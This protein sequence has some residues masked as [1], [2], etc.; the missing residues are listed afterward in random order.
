MRYKVQPSTPCTVG[1]A[2]AFYVGLSRWR[3]GPRPCHPCQQSRLSALDANDDRVPVQLRRT[4]RIRRARK[5]KSFS[6]RLDPWPD[7]TA[8]A[9]CAN[10]I[11]SRKNA[12]Q[13][14][15]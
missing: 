1:F 5:D 15:F 2:L 6:F 12:A 14:R 11:P 10:V 7:A 3:Q 8:N 13:I 9:V 4:L